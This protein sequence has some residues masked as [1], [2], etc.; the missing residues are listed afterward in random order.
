MPTDTLGVNGNIAAGIVGVSHVEFGDHF[1]DDIAYILARR[2][3]F[4]HFGV[5]VMHVFPVQA[6]HVRVVEEVALDTPRF[7]E[8]LLPFGAGINGRGHGGGRNGFACRARA[9]VLQGR[10]C[11]PRNQDFLAVRA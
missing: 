10:A 6:V 8:K 2:A 7:V 4:Q 5:L 1:A 9:R 11:A 3:A